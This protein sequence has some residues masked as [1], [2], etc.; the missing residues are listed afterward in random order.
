MN[1]QP[2]SRREARETVFCLIFEM[3]YHRGDAPRKVYDLAVENRDINHDPYIEDVF[4]KVFDN[5][6][7]I[8]DLITVSSVGW[9]NERM[10]KVTLSVLRL[11][12]CEMKYTDEI[13]VAV[14][15]NEA[16]ELCKKY[17][18]EGAAAFVNGVLGAIEKRE[19]LS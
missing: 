5:L 14:A 16:V 8:D 9:K 15:I 7:A 19:K 12:I 10:S 18:D 4:F 2:M 1:S 17:D 13:S 6:S 3:E 11:A